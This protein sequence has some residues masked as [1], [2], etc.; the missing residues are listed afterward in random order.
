M[1]QETINL[2]R[3]IYQTNDIIP[4]HAPSFN[5]SEEDLVSE[6]VKSTFVSSVGGYVD[7]FE[8]AMKT[9]TQSNGAVSTVNG[10][11]ALHAALYMAG[12]KSGDLVI[13]QS[14]TFIATCNAICHMG[15]SPIFLDVNP[16]HF[17]LCP[18]SLEYFLDTKTEINDDGNCI[19]KD[20]GQIIRAI[21]PMHT[22]GH[23]VDI[24]PILKLSQNA[25][26]E[27]IEDAAESLGSFYKNKHTG[28]FGRFSAI[29]FNG[30]KIITTG[31][32]GM[33][34]CKS[35][36][37]SI[38][39]KHITTT[40]KLSHPYEF[41]HDELG[42]NYRLPNINAALGVAQMNKL[43]SFLKSKREIA[44]IYK[45]F[46]NNYDCTFV[47]EP[48][49]GRSNY[50]LNAILC[51]DKDHRNKFLEKTNNQKINTRPV[52]N[53]MHQLPMFKNCIKSNLENSLFLQDRIVNL[54]SSPKKDKYDF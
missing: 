21:V 48:S 38:K 28:T 18:N 13:T 14:L 20:T 5:S 41:Y 8:S 39:L 27:L 50:W 47:E 6:T 52:W 44:L 25:N 29:S 17:G 12:V 54:P 36:E 2:I 10:T 43:E 40:A 7:E 16:N 19:Y 53:L 35:K 4:L 26:I 45:K 23:P 37:D 30:N 3:D 9:Y 46:F 42:F 33:I 32:G 31:G 49:Y 51:K 22:F 11:A 1:I 24:E 15:A 34:L